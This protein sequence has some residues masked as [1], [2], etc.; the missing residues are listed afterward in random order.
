MER[1]CCF[2]FCTQ[3]D[4]KAVTGKVEQRE[5]AVVMQRHCKQVQVQVILRPTVSRSVLLGVEPPMERL[6]RC[7]VPLSDNYFIFH[8]GCP[9]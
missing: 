4:L 8:V 2:A 6:I 3:C 7:Y 9:L 1:F 5:T